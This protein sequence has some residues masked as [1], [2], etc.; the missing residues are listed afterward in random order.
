MKSD[1]ASRCPNYCSIA[2]ELLKGATAMPCAPISGVHNQLSKKEHFSLAHQRL[3][4]ACESI[5]RA[6]SA[7]KAGLSVSM[8][9]RCTMTVRRIDDLIETARN[10]ADEN[11]DCREIGRWKM[12]ALAYLTEHLGEDHH[13]TQCFAAYVRSGEQEGLLA[14]GGLLA[15]A[16]EEISKAS[17]PLRAYR[18]D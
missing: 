7:G 8:N 18:S 1:N 10:A 16:K 15:A 12:E 3:L 2:A 5:G 14:G 6:P 4:H 11:L 13:Y 9:E 17:Y